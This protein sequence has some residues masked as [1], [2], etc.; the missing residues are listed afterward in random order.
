MKRLTY[1]AP[2]IALAAG[3][4]GCVYVQDTNLH[5]KGTEIDKQQATQ[6]EPGKT[7]KQWVLANLGTPDRI[8]AD[9]DGLEIFEYVS[10]RTEHSARKFILLFSLEKDRIVSRKVTR[11]VMRGGVVESISTTDA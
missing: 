4:T 2:A 10:E 8:H 1:L 3:L 11:V 6:V 7:D 5:R 9:K